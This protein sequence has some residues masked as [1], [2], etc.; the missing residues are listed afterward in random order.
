MVDLDEIMR[1]LAS[2]KEEN[3]KMR[4]HIEKFKTT[5]MNRIIGNIHPVNT[6]ELTEQSH[7]IERKTY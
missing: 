6:S 2:M 5:Q 7:Q 3:I 4:E 1:R